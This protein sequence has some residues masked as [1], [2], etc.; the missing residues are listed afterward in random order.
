MASAPPSVAGATGT[1]TGTVSAATQQRAV[2]YAEA[3]IGKPYQWGA[4][5]PNSFDCSGLVLYAWRA[6][7]VSLDH[8]T[9]A[10]WDETTH[11]PIAQLQPQ[12]AS[13]HG[14]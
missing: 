6:G 10:Q 1:V 12:L 2:S 8:S 13:D 3:Q 7:G 4:A 5:G 9:Y 11:I 14:A